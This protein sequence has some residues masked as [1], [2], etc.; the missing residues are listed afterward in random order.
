M[1]GAD[2]R[3]SLNQADAESYV[4]I[5]TMQLQVTFGKRE[6]RE[7]ARVFAEVLSRYPENVLKRAYSRAER[8]LTAFPSPKV[9]RQLCNE[10][11]PPETWRYNYVKT[12]DNTGTPCLID[13]ATKEKL[14]LPQH[15]EEGR[16]YLKVFAAI[17]KRSKRG[18]ED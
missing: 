9:M 18:A 15:C 8:E 11:M 16:E 1:K 17:A 13:P 7:M 14:Y 5:R 2:W 10:E 3:P 6:N 12:A 4:K